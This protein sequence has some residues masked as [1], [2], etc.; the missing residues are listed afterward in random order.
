MAKP[1][2]GL[3]ARRRAM[4]Y[5]QE[6][7]AELL[8]ITP[9]TVGRWEQGKSTPEP[10]L[11][12]RLATALEVSVQELI[13]LLNPQ[14]DSPADETADTD[15]LDR[16]LANP[17]KVDLV[18]VAEL[19]QHIALLSHRYDGERSTGLL[20]E[21]GQAL[22]QTRLLREH[23][24]EYRV[25]RDL[26][27][28]EAEASTLMGQFVWDASQRRDHD[29]AKGHFTTAAEAARK[30]ND[31]VLEAIAL[32]R[33]SYV[34]LY[35]TEDPAEGLVL[36]ERAADVARGHSDVLT[37]L[38]EIHAAEARAMLG[39]RVAC[40]RSL[41]RA[42]DHFGRI[43]ADEPVVEMF[44]ETQHDRLAG[45]CYLRL[46]EASKAQLTLERVASQAPSRSKS[47]SIVLANLSLAHIQQRELD[48]A[49]AALHIAID[50]VEA[51]WGGGGLKVIFGVA[52]EL[53]PWRKEPVVDQVYDRLFTMM[54]AS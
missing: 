28:A 27:A 1:R 5:S 50:S 32:L 9:G 30:I 40:E 2:K 54:A 6:S 48:H 46:N 23:A 4:G 16:A 39:E 3:A 45:S 49:A 38:A 18:T 31:P 11:Q 20:A 10:W 29:A 21:A 24:R 42:Q 15:R 34:E 12:P 14:A 37:G 33:T 7:L 17:S 13:D 53:R 41:E 35:G 36:T 51:T 26:L 8:R 52:Q 25:K 47:R 43:S 22:G 44:S 19:R